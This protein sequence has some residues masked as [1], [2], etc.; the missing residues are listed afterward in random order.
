MEN[1]VTNF[2][3]DDDEQTIQISNNLQDLDQSYN[4][5][6]VRTLVFQVVDTNG[7]YKTT[8]GKSSIMN[9]NVRR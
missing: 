5:Y 4:N 1:N 2:E 9:Y 6:L 7:I 8:D 3:P